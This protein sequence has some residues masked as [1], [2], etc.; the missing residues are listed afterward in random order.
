MDAF[1]DMALQFEKA[2][3]LK[4]IIPDDPYLSTLKVYKAY[5]SPYVQY[6]QYKKE[7]FGALAAFCKKNKVRFANFDEFMRELLPLLKG[8]TQATKFTF[9]G[10]LKSKS[11]SI[12]ASGL[13]F[14]VADLSYAND[15]EKIK[16]F[17]ESP[18]WQ[19][20][21]NTC[22]SYGFMV[23]LNI[24]WRIVA[25]LDSELTTEIGA[26]YGMPNI[27]MVFAR[28]Y[29]SAP[30]LTMRSFTQDLLALYNECKVRNYKVATIREG[31]TSYRRVTPMTYDVNTLIKEQGIVEIMKY[32]LQIRLYEEKP[33][34]SDNDMQRLISKTVAIGQARDNYPKAVKEFETVINKEFDKLRSYEYIKRHVEAKADDLFEQGLIEAIN[35][36]TLDI[37]DVVE[38]ATYEEHMLSAA[39]QMN[40]GTAPSAAS[41]VPAYLDNQAPTDESTTESP[42]NYGATTN[43]QGTVR[44]MVGDGEG[45]ESL[46]DL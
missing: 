9:S 41:P 22:D 30:I 6:Q 17:I 34:L 29:R 16:R 25:D 21:I 12:L 2:S 11:C 40:A 4:N 33:D 8:T 44:A 45:D 5:E 38:T 18:N 19:F 37:S 23:D 35:E 13:S 10:F 7:Y 3:S 36:E 42:A 1:R 32:Y 39:D 24:P 14:E 28:A 27:E 43:A 31:C 46:P 15:E 20:Y 26:R